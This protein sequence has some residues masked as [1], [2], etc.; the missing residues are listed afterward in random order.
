M[1][2]FLVCM[3]FRT[4]I[5]PCCISQVF[6]IFIMHLLGVSFGGRIRVIGCPVIKNS[7]QIYIGR[8]SDLRSVSRYT[9][10]GVVQRCQLNTLL[11][12]SV[13]SIGERCG[14]SGVV[15]CAK[16]RITIGNR[17]QIGSGVIV[18]D[19][20]FHSMDYRERGGDEDLHNA[21]SAPVR[22]GNDC[23]IGAR[24][25]VLKGVTIGARSIVGAGS[26]VVQDVPPDV[27]VAGNPARVIKRLTT[28]SS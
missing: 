12:T 13:I 9:A 27:V 20:D 21:A 5:F 4:L 26:V 15:I 2:V 25:I 6:S 24:A 16:E 7:G 17:V 28:G 14:M 23:F 22:I 18:C 19:T 11:P 1:V 3:K 8:G 10:M